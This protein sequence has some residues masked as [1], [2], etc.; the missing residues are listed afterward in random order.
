MYINL[1]TGKNYLTFYTFV[2]DIRYANSVKRIKYAYVNFT[3]I[4]NSVLKIL[5]KKLDHNI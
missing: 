4:D 5:K 2:T 1:A 3:T